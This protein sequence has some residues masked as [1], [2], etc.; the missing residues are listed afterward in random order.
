MTLVRRLS[1][2]L[3]LAALRLAFPEWF[4]SIQG[5]FAGLLIL[6]LEFGVRGEQPVQG[7]PNRTQSIRRPL[8]LGQM[9]WDFERKA[10]V[11]SR[12]AVQLHHQP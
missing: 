6:P 7:P 9:R 4:R 10:I 12:A 11:A 8:V 2:R 5:P 1:E 3:A